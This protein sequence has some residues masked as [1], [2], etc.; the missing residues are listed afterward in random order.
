MQQYVLY[1]PHLTIS[2]EWWK[3][4]WMATCFLNNVY[5]CYLPAHCSHGLQPLDNGVFNTLKATYRRELEKFA[6]LTDSVP[7]DKVNFI[8]AYAKARRV[9]MTKKKI[10]SGW[11]VTGNWPISRAKALRHPE[12]QQDRPNG[13]PRATP[14]PTVPMLNENASHCSLFV[15]ANL[16]YS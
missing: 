3:D 10:L 8:R 14:E 12:I 5:C 15:R 2:A 13:S 16:D 9:G 6:S 1:F 11:R 4:E 7:M